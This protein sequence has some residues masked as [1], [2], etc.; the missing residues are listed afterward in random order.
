MLNIML[1]N[2]NFAQHTYYTNYIQI[3]I[4][5]SLI[6]YITDNLRKTVILECIMDLPHVI[7][8]E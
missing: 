5:K 8:I 4:N 3:S 6:Y 2:K 1:K 7:I